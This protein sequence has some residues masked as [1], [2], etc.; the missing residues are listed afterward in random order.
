MIY[1]MIIYWI[2]KKTWIPRDG[3]RFNEEIE[4][5]D[6]FLLSQL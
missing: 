1:Y 3:A 4:V 2:E 5:G 6:L